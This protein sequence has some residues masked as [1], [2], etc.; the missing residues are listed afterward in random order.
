MQDLSA[1]NC[2]ISIHSNI[3]NIVSL[4]VWCVCTADDYYGAPG[5]AGTTWRVWTRRSASTTR[6]SG[7][8]RISSWTI[9]TTSTATSGMPHAVCKR[10]FLTLLVL[11]FTSRQVLRIFHWIRF[12]LLI[13]IRLN[14]NWVFLVKS[15][16]IFNFFKGIVCGCY[17]TT[18]ILE[19]YET[20]HLLFELK[21]SLGADA[22]L[23]SVG[24][25]FW[26][27]LTRSASLPAGKKLEVK[28]QRWAL[29]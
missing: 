24:P 7:S 17:R 23:D 26:P 25:G 28:F 29:I 18:R 21:T 27:K 9:L 6:R 13:R 1:E 19:H 3:I 15:N 16:V 11:S 20:F 10:S 8:T 4:S 12:R 22:Y 5:C 14:F 2:K